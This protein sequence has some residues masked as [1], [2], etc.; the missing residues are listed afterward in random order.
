MRSRQFITKQGYQP[1]SFQ[2]ASLLLQVAGEGDPKDLYS[3]LPA[4][5][6]VIWTELIAQSVKPPV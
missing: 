3:P 2:H 4:V 6:W 5:G 1:N